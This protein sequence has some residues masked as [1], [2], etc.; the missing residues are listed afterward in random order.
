ME[1]GKMTEHYKSYMCYRCACIFATHADAA[2]YAIKAGY[3]SDLADFD[4][5]VY[6]IQEEGH[7]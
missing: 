6:E 3:A 4:A 1:T 7:A 2:A 5:R